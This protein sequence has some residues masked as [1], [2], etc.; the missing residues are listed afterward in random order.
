MRWGPFFCRNR[1]DGRLLRLGQ[2]GRRA[3]ALR[4]NSMTIQGMYAT[5]AMQIRNPPDITA[6]RPA[7]SPVP[8]HPLPCRRLVYFLFHTALGRNSRLLLVL[9]SDRISQSF[10]AFNNI[11]P[12]DVENR[13]GIQSQYCPRAS[14]TPKVYRKEENI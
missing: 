1:F 12:L 2:P 3:P 8:Y 10:A 13:T 9:E 6:C 5:Q 11:S 14:S 7:K 4:E